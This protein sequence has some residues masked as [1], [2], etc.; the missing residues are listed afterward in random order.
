MRLTLHTDYALR[1]LIYLAHRQQQASV[2]EIARAYGISKDHLFKVVQHPRRRVLELA[3]LLAPEAL[4]GLE[5]VEQ[6]LGDPRLAILDRVLKRV[7]EQF[8]L[9]AA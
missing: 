8:E 7:L 2:D 1:T 4:R 3:P 6:A 9:L 5:R